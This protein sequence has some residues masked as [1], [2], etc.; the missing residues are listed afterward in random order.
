MRG[1]GR[2]ADEL[3]VDREPEGAPLAQLTFD[4]DRAVIGLDNAL[5]ARQTDALARDVARGRVLS[6]S[7]DKEDFTEVLRVDADSRVTDVEFRLGYAD[8]ASHVDRLTRLIAH[9]FDGVVDQVLEDLPQTGL[10]A[11]ND[12]QRVIDHQ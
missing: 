6:S 2:A 5:H 11:L 4:P 12:G 8:C 3:P 7:E 10:F 9:V 1:H